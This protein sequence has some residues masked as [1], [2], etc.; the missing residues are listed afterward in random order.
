[1]D[2]Y[3]DPAD[4]VD[5]GDLPG[6]AGVL[7][8][9]RFRSGSRPASVAVL[10]TVAAATSTPIPSNASHDEVECLA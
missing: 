6:L 3:L 7:I 4:A 5:H 9:C 10:A 8:P 2:V 1:L